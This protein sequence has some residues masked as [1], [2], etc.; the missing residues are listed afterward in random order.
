MVPSRIVSKTVGMIAEKFASNNI[1][2]PH[3]ESI[4]EPHASWC[5]LYLKDMNSPQSNTIV[6]KQ[7]HSKHSW[8]IRKSSSEFTAWLREKKTYALFFDGASKGNPGVESAGGILMDPE[9]KIEQTYAW[10]IRC[11]TNNEAEW[12]ALL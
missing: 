8:E 9:G 6:N 2:F 10:G 3:S 5:K 4:S 1:N 12:T 7:I 11:R